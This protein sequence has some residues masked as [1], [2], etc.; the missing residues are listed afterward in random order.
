MRRSPGSLNARGNTVLWAGKLD[1]WLI[2]DATEELDRQHQGANALSI[3]RSELRLDV[4]TLPAATLAQLP[5]TGGKPGWG[6]HG[7]CLLRVERLLVL[8]HERYPRALGWS[9]LRTHP[10]PPARTRGWRVRQRTPL[11]EPMRP[12]IRSVWWRPKARARARI[13]QSAR[14]RIASHCPRDPT[15]RL[16]CLARRGGRLSPCPTFPGIGNHI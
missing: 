11:W 1:Y 9:D 8:R 2:G 3:R 16:S 15:S 4:L 5:S 13:R 7:G 10:E 14:A 12:A 6:S